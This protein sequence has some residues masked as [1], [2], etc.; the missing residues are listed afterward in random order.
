MCVL[1]SLTRLPAA[2]MNYI[3]RFPPPVTTV[4]WFVDDGYRLLF[5]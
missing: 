1:H 4:S 5:G 3:L 2:F